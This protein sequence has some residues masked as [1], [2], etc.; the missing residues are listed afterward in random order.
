MVSA[1]GNKPKITGVT[2]GKAV[3]NV[4]HPG[5]PP[6]TAEFALVRDD[7]EFCGLFE[8]RLEWSDKTMKAIAALQEAMEGD[9]LEALFEVPPPGSAGTEPQQV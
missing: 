6:L 4:L 8:K 9:A 2:L 7:G 5:I 3:L 1:N